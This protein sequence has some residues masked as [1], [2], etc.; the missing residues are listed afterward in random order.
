[1]QLMGKWATLP[2]SYEYSEQW[3]QHSERTFFLLEA[4]LFIPGHAK[5]GCNGAARA[6][7]EQGQSHDGQCKLVSKLLPSGTQLQTY[8]CIIILSRET[9]AG[10]QVSVQHPLSYEGFPL[11]LQD[12]PDK[13]LVQFV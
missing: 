5:H 10:E 9:M 7:S 11:G 3:S 2:E 1:M 6:T 12:C 4:C 13:E 8:E